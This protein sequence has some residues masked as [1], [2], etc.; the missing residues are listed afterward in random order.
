MTP[1]HLNVTLPSFSNGGTQSFRIL[2]QNSPMEPMCRTNAGYFG[3]CN[4]HH[5]SNV[6]DLVSIELDAD[7]LPFV[8]IFIYNKADVLTFL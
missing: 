5:L 6:I 8:Y 1:Y 7:D 4:P 2:R 3:F